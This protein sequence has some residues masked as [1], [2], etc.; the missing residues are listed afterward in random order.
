M[1]TSIVEQIQVPPNYL[2]HL[3]RSP[4]I[5][6]VINSIHKIRLSIRGCYSK[7]KTNMIFRHNKPGKD[8]DFEA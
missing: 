6:T 5:H 7:D 8:Q 3:V 4:L 2:D 1:I